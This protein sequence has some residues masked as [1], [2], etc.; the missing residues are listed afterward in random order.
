MHQC[1]FMTDT[2]GITHS[3]V[4]IIRPKTWLR[5]V[6]IC[7]G[8]FGG[9]IPFFIGLDL[10]FLLFSSH[11]FLS[12]LFGRHVRRGGRS[13]SALGSV[14]ADARPSSQNLVWVCLECITSV[15]A[16]YC[17]CICVCPGIH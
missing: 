12:A 15:C 13:L 8:C 9:K 16:V 1:M 17:A 11:L 10:Y 2:A 4:L 6:E 3:I 7:P 5:F 14:Q